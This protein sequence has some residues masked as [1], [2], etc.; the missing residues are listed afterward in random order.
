MRTPVPCSRQAKSQARSRGRRGA[1]RE[2]GN[3]VGGDGAGRGHVGKHA[4]RGGQLE[5]EGGAGGCT[6]RQLPEA[7]S[8][9]LCWGCCDPV[10]ASVTA[11]ADAD[12]GPGCRRHRNKPATPCEADALPFHRWGEETCRSHVW[13]LNPAPTSGRPAPLCRGCGL[14]Y[15]PL[16]ATG[17]WGPLPGSCS[18]LSKLGV[19]WTLGDA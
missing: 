5:W 17:L 7:H 16:G 11:V 6:G 19:A 9:G 2:G 10:R 15:W 13:R 4:A 3:R 18:G 14:N 1:G 8:G 12:V